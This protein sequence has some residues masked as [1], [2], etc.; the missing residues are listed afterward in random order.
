M[1]LDKIAFA[2]LVA[3]VAGIVQRGIV[4]STDV[5]VLDKLIDIPMAEPVKSYALPSEVDALLAAMNQPGKKIEAIKAYRVL[6]NAG[7]KEAKDAVERYWNELP[8]KPETGSLG[9]ILDQAM[10]K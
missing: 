9:Y 10:K 1:K 4:D 3:F 2:K 7:L 8:G 5:E 6:T